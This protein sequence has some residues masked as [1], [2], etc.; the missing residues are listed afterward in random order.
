MI[1]LAELDR[2]GSF[3]KFAAQVKSVVGVLDFELAKNISYLTLVGAATGKNLIVKGK[4]LFAIGEDTDVGVG[5]AGVH[6][7]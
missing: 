3:V 7:S 4:D 2:E 6:G 1:G 5:N